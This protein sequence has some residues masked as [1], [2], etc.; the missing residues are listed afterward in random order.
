M[1]RHRRSPWGIACAALPLLIIGCA[2]TRSMIPTRH[3]AT[4]PRQA[5]SKPAKDPELRV[6]L[7]R[8]ESEPE[9]SP[10]ATERDGPWPLDACIARAL[11]GNATIR[12]AR[13]NIL[14]LQHRIP[15]VTSLDDPFVSN[16][17]FPIPSVAPQFS[18][19]GY[20]PYDALIAQQFPWFGTL[21]LRGRAAEQDV[22]IALYELAATQLDVVAGVKRAYYDLHYEEQAE[23]LLSRNRALAEDFLS[24]ARDRYRVG[25]ATQSDVLRAEVALSD[26][27]RELESTRAA[28]NEA[29]VELTRLLHLGSEIDIRT[30]P[31]AQRIAVPSELGRLQQ[32]AVAARP[33]LQGRLAAIARDH[34]AVELARK[35]YY[36]NVTVGAVYQDMERRNAESPLAGGMPNIGLFVGVNLPVYRKKLAAGV[37]EA[38][39]RASAD[40]ALYEA[41]RDQSQRDIKDLFVQARVQK[42]ILDLL[43]RTNLPAA[44]QVLEATS[45]DY[46]AGNEGVDFLSVLSA[47]RD[48]LQVELQVAQ[49]EAE[50]AK[51]LASLERAVGVQLN[52]HPPDSTSHAP[53][54]PPPPDEDEAAAPFHP[55]G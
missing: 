25:N 12:A 51:T 33:D 43:N 41:E 3:P 31:G 4:V 46:R 21:R 29:R 37:C 32:L 15:Q 8:P 26:I 36:P 9:L 35:R 49:L 19:M 6:T 20:M 48:L 18:L 2:Q 23:E 10:Y 13:F 17:I 39:A 52:E 7:H 45:S 27:D 5:A 1:I 50:L 28:Q 11:E 24:V 30:T 14:A 42:N 53:A 47:W 40:A 38:Q 54:E 34:E 22:K 16:T 55:E 44:R